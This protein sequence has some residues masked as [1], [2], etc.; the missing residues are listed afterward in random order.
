MCRPVSV[1]LSVWLSGRLSAFFINR[2]GLFD[3]KGCVHDG[4]SGV[5]V[6]RGSNANLITF[7]F[8]IALRDGTTKETTDQRTYRVTYKDARTLLETKGQVSILFRNQRDFVF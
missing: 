8:D 2:D 4:I 3:E 1:F 5:W 7:W 6:G